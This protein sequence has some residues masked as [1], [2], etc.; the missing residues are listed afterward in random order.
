MNQVDK[1]MRSFHTNGFHRMWLKHIH[2]FSLIP[3]ISVW[4]W[5][6]YT[7]ISHTLNIRYLRHAHTHSQ[8]NTYQT[9]TQMKNRA[10]SLCFMPNFLHF[11]ADELLVFQPN[12]LI[13]W[14]HPNSIHSEKHW[15]LLS[16]SLRSKD[17]IRIQVDPED[18]LS[19]EVRYLPLAFRNVEKTIHWHFSCDQEIEFRKKS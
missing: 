13:H 19:Y 6:W 4:K 15:I 9:Q 14:K 11:T 18:C 2:T 12:T 3:A 1:E 10:N 7:R 5:S 8:K 16:F 17:S